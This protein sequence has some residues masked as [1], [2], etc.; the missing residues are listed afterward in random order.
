[1]SVFAIKEG[2]RHKKLIYLSG[3]IRTQCAKAEGWK[4]QA[5]AHCFLI[6]TWELAPVH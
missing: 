3:H 2:H 4:R 6:S 5:I 1:M